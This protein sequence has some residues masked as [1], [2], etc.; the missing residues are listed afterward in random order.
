LFFFFFSSRRRH[1]RWPRDWSSDVCSSD[2]FVQDLLR[3]VS[4]ETL[5]V[6]ERKSRHLAAAALLECESDEEM[7]AIV[8][9]H[10]LDA[11]RASSGDAD[12]PELRVQARAA[13]TRAAERA[14][15]LASAGEAARYFTQAAELMDDALEQAGLLELAGRA[16]A[17]DA[18]LERA[19]AL[20]QRAS[21]LLHSHGHAHAAARVDARRA[22]VFR[23]ADRVDE[24]LELVQSAYDALPR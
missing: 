10:Y 14:S 18:D 23:L 17:Q 9:A 16:A 11:Y 15:S 19:H 5:S 12:A 21:E 4:Y 6:R 7:A 1:T 20:L 3:R 24:A 22:D 8:A 2:L 13:L